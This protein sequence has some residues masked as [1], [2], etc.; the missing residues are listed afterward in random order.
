MKSLRRTQLLWLSLGL[1]FLAACATTELRVTHPPDF[2][3]PMRKLTSAVKAEMDNPFSSTRPSGDQLLTAAMRDKPELQRAFKDTLVLIT[4][5]NDRAV[6]LLL[7][8]T[9]KNVAWL[10]FPTWSRELERF[11]FL[12]NPPSP[13]EFTIPLSEP[14]A[15]PHP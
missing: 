14:V 3:E 12:S 11:H 10:E 5:Q 9:N 4:N 2:I 7:S 13:A 8:L 15:Q 6:V 1:G